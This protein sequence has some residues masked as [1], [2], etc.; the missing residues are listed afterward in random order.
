MANEW[1][2]RRAE[3][4]KERRSNHAVLREAALEFR[5]TIS[6]AILQCLDDYNGLFPGE[7]RHITTENKGTESVIRRIADP[8]FKYTGK[9]PEVGLRIEVTQLV[10]ICTFP[11]HP[12]RDVTFNL[13]RAEDGSVQLAETTIELACERILDPILFNK[14]PGDSV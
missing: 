8:D 13:I 11:N 1:I 6:A 12:E 10:M 3:Q 5:E 9:V 7:G 4:E 14:L 2:A